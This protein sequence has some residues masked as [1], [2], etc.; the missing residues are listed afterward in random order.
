MTLM[1]EGNGGQCWHKHVKKC[2]PRSVAYLLL[3]RV[4]ADLAVR[5]LVG[6]CNVLPC[7][8]RFPQGHPVQLPWR[9]R[10]SYQQK[11]QASGWSLDGWLQG[12][13]LYHFTRYRDVTGNISSLYS[14]VD[15]SSLHMPSPYDACVLA[16]ITDSSVKKI[17]LSWSYP[18]VLTHV[19]FM[20]FPLCFLLHLIYTTLVIYNLGLTTSYSEKVFFLSY[21]GVHKCFFRLI[22]RVT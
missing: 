15:M 17:C 3:L 11:Q 9:N 1:A 22:P 10:P 16:D 8:A 14:K 12:F 20:N 18:S 2:H 21:M 6:D 13:L 4:S 19:S 5:G 7:G